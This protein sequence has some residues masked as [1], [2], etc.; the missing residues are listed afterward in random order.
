M[1][2]ETICIFASELSGLLDY[3]KIYNKPSAYFIDRIKIRNKEQAKHNINIVTVA[4]KIQ[5]NIALNDKDIKFEKKAIAMINGEY[6]LNTKEE[7]I[8]TE[9]K[10]DKEI[11][12]L[13]IGKLKNNKDLNSE[14]LKYQA[15]S[16]GII[17]EE[18]CNFKK[19]QQSFKKYIDSPNC[20][21][22]ICIYGKVDGIEDDT[23]IEFKTRVNNY[24][25]GPR[26]YEIPQ[27]MAYMF[28]SDTDKLI[29]IEQYNDNVVRE[30][31]N[32]DQDTW[33]DIIKKIINIINASF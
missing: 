20:K 12:S 28:L 25:N 10:K 17:T 3:L 4:D 5:N 18:K 32:F 30:N 22:N 29:F 14:E 9:K 16:K 8:I 23:I 6:N 2:K 11:M 19:N 31:I 27:A 33:D 7:I 15:V 1:A 26:R 21:F 13:V 24:L